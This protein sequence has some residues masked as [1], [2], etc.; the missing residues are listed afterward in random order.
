[1][2]LASIEVDLN[3]PL[4]FQLLQKVPSELLKG[5]LQ[6]RDELAPDSINIA[7]QPGVFLLYRVFVPWTSIDD[8]D[9]SVWIRMSDESFMDLQF[10][11]FNHKRFKLVG[12]WVER[13]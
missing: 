8:K 3:G 11:D 10:D 6:Q 12:G 1:M 5:E 9:D 2:P 13:A 4:L 7:D